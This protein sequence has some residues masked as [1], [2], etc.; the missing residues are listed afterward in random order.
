MQAQCPTATADAIGPQEDLVEK[1]KEAH[2]GTPVVGRVDIET[3]DAFESASTPAAMSVSSDDSLEEVS[4]VWDL[5]SDSD[6]EDNCSM[7]IHF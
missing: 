5:G 6:S 1:S 2:E 7:E 4:E 3:A